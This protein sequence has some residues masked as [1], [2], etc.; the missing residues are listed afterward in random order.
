M[1]D[2]RPDELIRAEVL[3][4]NAK[5]EEAL[6]IVSKFEKRNDLTTKDQLSVLLL[7]GVIYNLKFQH[8]K[9]VEIG[10]RAYPL[11]QELGLVSESIEALTLKASMVFLGKTDKSLALSLDA[12]KLLK[13]LSDES[14]ANVS[15]LKLNLNLVILW[16]YSFRSEYDIALNLAMEALT[17]GKKIKNN[18]AVGFSLG[19]SSFIYWNKGEHD[20]ALEYGMKCLKLFEKLDFQAGIAFGHWCMGHIYSLKGDLNKALESCEKAL[21]IEEI[22]DTTKSNILYVLIRVYRGKGELDK[23]LKYAKQGSKLVEEISFPVTILNRSIG[24]IY[25]TKGEKN[26]AIKHFEQS[27]V[28][29]EKIGYMPGV[30]PAL[31]CLLLIN[32]D[33]N[34]PEQ[35]QEYLKRLENFSDQCEGTLVR[36]GY[37]LGKALMLK[38]SSRMADHTDAARLLRQIVDDNILWP[39]FHIL[40]I[41]SMCDLLLEE[42][43]MYNNPDIIDELNPLIIQLLE[44]AEKNNSFSLLSETY[45]LQGRVALIKLNLDDARQY[46]T[47]AQQ[48]ADEHDLSLLSRK[49]SFEHDKLVEELETWKNLKKTQ[50]SM[51]KRIKLAAI[52]GVMDRIQEKRAVDPPELVDEQSTLLLIIAEGGVPLFSYP[53]TEEWKQDEALFSSFLSAITSFSDEFFSEKLDRVKFGEETLLMQLTDNFSFC[54]LYKG[55]TYPA[56]K[57]LTKFTE[58]VQ[59]NASIWDTLEKFYKTNQVLELKDNPLLESLIDEIFISK[60]I[61]LSV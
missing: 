17:L 7:K 19:S 39:Q 1:F 14:P 47:K 36:H 20:I 8:K 57:K 15:K 45:L 22:S 46:L 23:A 32:L 24:E 51:S 50:V 28:L 6:K 9:A 18:I 59:N 52:D 43:S 34:S 12:E 10:E 44:I 13:S 40:A 56:K 42:L 27:L 31:L 25:M 38:A 4:Y 30:V 33:S 11:S 21:E 60:S 35:A 41:I 5:V 49:I 3:L 54:Y 53:F 16:I 61:E 58:R 29:N 48:I 37:P 2:S 55:Q 26:Q